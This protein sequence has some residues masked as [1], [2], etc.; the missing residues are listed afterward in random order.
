MACLSLV[1]CTPFNA[2]ALAIQ[3]CMVCSLPSLSG[4]LWSD[5]WLLRSLR[6]L[7]SLWR[8]VQM[9]PASI[10][11]LSLLLLAASAP[12]AGHLSA[13]GVLTL[14]SGSGLC[15]AVGGSSGV[16][17]AFLPPS[18]QNQSTM[19]IRAWASDTS[20]LTWT[21]PLPSVHPPRPVAVT[22]GVLQSGAQAGLPPSY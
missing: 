3:I 13:L 9:P 15:F 4:N 2:D 11:S 22:V 18:D 17:G 19:D 1:W 14:Q 7:H 10:D 16:A 20:S 21:V 8:T 6:S 12:V 5:S